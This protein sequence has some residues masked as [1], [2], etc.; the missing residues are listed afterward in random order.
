MADLRQ[1]PIGALSGGQKRR[2]FIARALAQETDVLLLDEPFSGVDAAA[3]QE[4]METLE[5]LQGAGITVLLATHDLHFASM[6]ANR[7]LA[8][9]QRVIAYDAPN[10]VFTPEILDQ[11][12]GNRVRIFRQGDQTMVVAGDYHGLS[13]GRKQ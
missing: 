5:R 1:R 3:E 4:I 8:L 12:Y 13:N 10:A 6:K 11:V 2:V 7:L 9:K